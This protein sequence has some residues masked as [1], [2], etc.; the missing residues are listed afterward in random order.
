[1]IQKGDLVPDSF[2]DTCVTNNRNAICKALGG[3]SLGE[4]DGGFWNGGSF[5]SGGVENSSPGASPSPLQG[6]DDEGWGSDSDSSF[7]DDAGC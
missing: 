4:D 7:S 1:M 2:C 6:G 5:E 3:G